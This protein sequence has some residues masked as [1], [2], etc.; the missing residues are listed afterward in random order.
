MEKEAFFFFLVN[1]LSLRYVFSVKEPVMSPAFICYLS[2]SLTVRQ[3]SGSCES[4]LLRQTP[5]LQKLFPSFSNGKNILLLECL[6]DYSRYTKSNACHTE[7]NNMLTAPCCRVDASL[8][9][10]D[11]AGRTNYN[12]PVDTNHGVDYVK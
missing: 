12:H 5:D 10:A 1:N 4:V 11:H 3:V 8:T 2:K 9:E 7:K 6:S